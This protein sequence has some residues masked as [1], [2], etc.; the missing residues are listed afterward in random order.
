[1]R[2]RLISVGE[3]MPGWVAEGFAEYAKRL[4]RELPLELVE[5]RL[6]DRGKGRDLGRALEDE[7]TA[8]LAAIPRGFAARA[9]SATAF[10]MEVANSQEHAP[11]N[12]SA[13][14]FASCPMSTACRTL[15]FTAAAKGAK[16]C[17][18]P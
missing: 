4:S 5:L 13:T 10:S 18:L 15:F 17:P 2:A 14:C 12:A 16:S 8:M 11:A 3:R 6:G 9:A 1:M 7:G